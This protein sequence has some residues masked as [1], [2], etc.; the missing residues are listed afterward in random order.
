MAIESDKEIQQLKKRFIEL[1]E[2]SY[3]Q[4]IYTFTGFLGMSEQEIFWQAAQAIKYVPF[5]LWGGCE[6]CERQMIR[7]GSM[8]EFG[9]EE[10]FPIVCIC[11]SPLLEKF[12]DNL[13]HRDFLGALMNLGIERNTL[14]DIYVNH[15]TGY[16][17]CTDKIAPFILENLDKIK[18]TN[19]KCKVVEE[20]PK[21]VVGEAEE[22]EQLTASERIDGII[23]K[24]YNISRTQSLELFR[25]KKVFV[26][27]RL[28]ENNSCNLKSGDTV[29][30][31]GYGKFTYEG[32]VQE[33]RK[34]K[35]RIK[36]Q[37][38]R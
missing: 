14:G 11:I 4:N 19:V 8:E 31:R 37:I 7:F 25:Q 26:N 1:G 35:L 12:A 22:E 23:A 2:K 34:G 30:V 33:T 5:T 10:K 20:I 16:L 36:V 24:L 38:F 3:N 17:F 15:K 29:S 32:I 18:H 9:Y 13:T 27:G 28:N 6:G 21:I